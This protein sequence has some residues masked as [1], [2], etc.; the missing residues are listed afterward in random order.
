M[1]DGQAAGLRS[2]TRFTLG[3]APG[4]MPGSLVILCGMALGPYGLGLLSARVL[5]SFDPVMPVAL[6]ALGVFIGIQFN[7]RLQRDWLALAAASLQ[8]GVTMAIVGAGVVLLTRGWPA[9]TLEPPAWFNGMVLAIGAADGPLPVLLSGVALAFLRDGLPG[10]AAMLVLQ[11]TGVT[12]AIAGAGWLL[13]SR[14]AEGPERRIFV[15][16]LLL[17]LGGA[18]DYLSLSALTGGLIAGVLWEAADGSTRQAIWRDLLYVQRPL[19]GLILVVSGARL[20]M[21]PAVLALG[22]PYLALRLLGSMAGS[23]AAQRLFPVWLATDT[24]LTSLSHGIVGLAFA[25]NAVRAAG[26]DAVTVLSVVVVGAIGSE[27][28]APILMPRK[29]VE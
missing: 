2:D 16:A 28:L 15:I 7:L 27:L 4:A 23:A 3:F 17:L 12:L 5:D 29:A 18:S 22:L 20:D 10:A 1:T 24:R 13:L 14:S 19:I 25:L 8:A 9:A 21:T 6:A 26:P 11:A